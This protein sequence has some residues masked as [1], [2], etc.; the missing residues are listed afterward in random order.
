MFEPKYVDRIE[1]SKWNQF[2]WRILI[3]TKHSY[4]LEIEK[5]H[6]SAVTAKKITFTLD[7][8]ITY[9]GWDDVVK[10]EL[11]KIKKESWM[12]SMTS[13]GRAGAR[14]SPTGTS[15]PFA[16]VNPLGSTHPARTTS[17]SMT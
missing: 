4:L 15:P 17:T 2:F 8:I 3:M 12:N 6:D 5:L 7:Y 1:K 10:E 14:F 11:R 16:M 13:S 9:G